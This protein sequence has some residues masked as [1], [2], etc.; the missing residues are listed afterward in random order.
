[1]Q[2]SQKLACLG[3]SRAAAEYLHDDNMAKAISKVLFFCTLLEPTFF[4]TPVTL[5]D[6]KT[7]RY[8]C[9]SGKLLFHNYYICKS[10]NLL[11]SS[12]P[13]VQNFNECHYSD[14]HSVLVRKVSQNREWAIMWHHQI[15]K[16]KTKEPLNI[17][18]LS[19]IRGTKFRSVYHFPA[20]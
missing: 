17:I 16:S 4:P 9:T 6:L 13:V 7:K 10:T 15:L 3:R 18:S 12:T 1:M 19:G 11:I 2:Q 20:P 8:V 5:G 14:H